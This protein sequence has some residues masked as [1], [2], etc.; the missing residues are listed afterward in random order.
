[1]ATRV[2]RRPTPEECMA[3]LKLDKAGLVVL[4]V[5]LSISAVMIALLV[6]VVSG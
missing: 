5:T 3:S 4:G 2:R 6:R 1:M